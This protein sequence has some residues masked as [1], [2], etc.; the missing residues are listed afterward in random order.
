MTLR[1]ILMRHAKS[2]WDDPTQP[3]HARPLNA[4]GRASAPAMGGWLRAR[5]IGPDLALISDAVR[6]CQTFDGLG[7]DCPAQFL[8]ELY[9]AGAASMMDVLQG[10]GAAQTVLMLGHNPGIAEFAERLLRQP[11][12]HPRFFDYPTCAT[13]VAEFAVQ[14]WADITFDTGAVVDFAVPREVLNG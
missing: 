5:G 6:T 13:L 8:P 9:H 2:D 1:L 7:L 4:R 10:A 12:S 11:P 14:D 3:D